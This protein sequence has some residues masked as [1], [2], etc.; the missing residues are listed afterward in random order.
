MA[1]KMKRFEDL[2][3]PEDLELEKLAS[4]SSEAKQKLAEHRPKTLGA[5]SKISG[6]SASDIS[7][8]MIY[9]GR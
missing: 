5:A 3:I 2:R 9:L 7:V 4:L 6:V 1:D 8:L